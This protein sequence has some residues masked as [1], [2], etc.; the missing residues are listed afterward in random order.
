MSFKTKFLELEMISQIKYSVFLL[1]VIYTF[2][3]L[4]LIAAYCYEIINQSYRQ[5]KQFF[6]DIDTST[7]ENIIQFQNFQFLLY[8]DLTK[9]A[10]NQ[11]LTYLSANSLY[12]QSE[13]V[14]AYSLATYDEDT[15]TFTE[16]TYNT[17]YTRVAKSTQDTITEIGST[18][19]N[20]EAKVYLPDGYI[21]S[22]YFVQLTPIGDHTCW[23]DEKAD[24]YFVI[25]SNDE[26][27]FTVDY[28][29]TLKI[30]EQ[31]IATDLM[32]GSKGYTLKQVNNMPEE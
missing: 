17:V 24:D 1:S 13:Q 29:I 16:S 26:S 14:S 9:T 8:E 32:S 21:Y 4:A 3:I 11:I 12:E 18:K 10:I 31:N 19:V 30:P 6:K 28:L 7:T 23:L 20:K 15:D 25:K 2:I 22:D 27:E 5:Q